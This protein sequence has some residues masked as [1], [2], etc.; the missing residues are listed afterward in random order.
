MGAALQYYLTFFANNR[1]IPALI[2]EVVAF[3]NPL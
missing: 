3:G 1:T 2:N